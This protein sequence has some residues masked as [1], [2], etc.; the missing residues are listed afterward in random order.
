[1]RGE[2]EQL[3]AV[4]AV[5][6]EECTAAGAAVIDGARLLTLDDLE[7]DVHLNKRGH[8]KLAR[9]VQALLP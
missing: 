8:A 9:A 7:D 6:A 3:A 4:R 2:T 5:I 1:V